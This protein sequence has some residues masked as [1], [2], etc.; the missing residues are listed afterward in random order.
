ML[1]E[2]TIGH[3]ASVAC[4][5]QAH[6]AVASEGCNP[7][8]VMRCPRAWAKTYEHA[9]DVTRASCDVFGGGK[10]SAVQDRGGGGGGRRKGFCHLNEGNAVRQR[11]D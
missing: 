10:C 8:A 5:P 1:D 9:D 11:H 6:D 7:H 3:T 4:P 2:D